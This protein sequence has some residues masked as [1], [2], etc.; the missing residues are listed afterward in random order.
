MAMHKPDLRGANKK[1]ATV[2][3]R[4]AAAAAPHRLRL[5]THSLRERDRFEVFREN[6]SRYLYPANVENSWEGTFD[7]GIELL[8]AGKRWHLEDRRTA[9][10][11]HANAPPPLRFR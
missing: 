4:P 1:E 10:D 6:F 8:R 9:V 11:L 2:P 5:S 7:G 3:Q